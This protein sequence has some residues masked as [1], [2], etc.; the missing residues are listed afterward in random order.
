V[1]E[2]SY[3]LVAIIY[4][5]VRFAFTR[6]L[7]ELGPY[8][9][10][11]LEAVVCAICVLLFGVKKFVGLFPIKRL[12]LK[13]TALSL[14]SGLAVYKAAYALE[15]PIAFQMQALETIVFL[16]VVAPILEELIF[17]FVLWQPIARFT[18]SPVAALVAT[19][20][21][22]SYAHLHAIW[23]VPPEFH[24][25]VY[26]QTTYTL[27][28]G[29]LCGFSLYKSNSLLSSMVLHFSF[30]LGFYLATRI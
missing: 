9:S 13:L 29:L 28:L 15:I 2:K 22:F 30:N 16:L 23:F 20:L 17:R 14:V 26:Y 25:F 10:Y 12:D 8:A 11:I 4:L 19:A 5:M 18:K 7:D 6:Q 27:F 3:L 24:A 1:F 21:L